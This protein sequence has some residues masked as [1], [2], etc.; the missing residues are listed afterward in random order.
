MTFWIIIAAL[1]LFVVALF[2]RAALRGTEGA[3]EAAA[4]DLQ[5]YRDQLKEVDR[6]L[7]RGVISEDEAERTRLEISRRILA[8]DAAI[9]GET[10]DHG[11]P[12]KSPLLIGGLAAVAVLG[13]SL[14]LYATIGTPG[15]RDLPIAM[16]TRRDSQS[17]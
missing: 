8:A 13:G 11:Q 4:Y 1:A 16:R 10:Q 3:T 6:D 7:A 17:Q 12:R 9:K 14:W 5:V 2:V 15:Y